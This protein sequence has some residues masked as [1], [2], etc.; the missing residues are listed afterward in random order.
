LAFAA[1]PRRPDQVQPVQEQAPKGWAP[2]PQKPARPTWHKVRTIEEEFVAA[3]DPLPAG[4]LEGLD[5]GLEL[6]P[7]EAGENPICL[8]C[9]A[10]AY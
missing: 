1:R 3:G 7:S 4:L 10:T 2:L 5:C 9:R 6:S 8:E